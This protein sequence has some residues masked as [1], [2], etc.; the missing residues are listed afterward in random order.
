MENPFRFPGQYY[1]AE[2]GLHYNYFRYYN[3]QTGRY[4]TPDPIGLEGGV[5]LFSYVQN[6]P[7]NKID[8]TGLQK[9]LQVRPGL[10]REEVIRGTRSE[11]DLKLY[12]NISELLHEIERQNAQLEAMFGRQPVCVKRLCPDGSILDLKKR[13]YIMRPDTNCPCI[14]Y[15]HVPKVL[16]DTGKWK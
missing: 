8:P 13:C 1:D 11:R 2:T 16:Y 12:E 5:N 9:G 14:E 15:E 4:I 3:P 10:S 7:T 6:S